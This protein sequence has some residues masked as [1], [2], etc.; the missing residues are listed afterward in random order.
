MI[1]FIEISATKLKFV[2]YPNIKLIS[3]FLC[4]VSLIL[5]LIWSLWFSSMLVFQNKILEPNVTK[6]YSFE[7]INQ[8]R[9]DENTSSKNIINGY[10]I[11]QFNPNYDYPIDEFIDF[12]Y[13]R[14]NFQIIQEFIV[15]YQ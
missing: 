7:R 10:I 1:K 6:E 4:L 3:Y 2:S 11:L 14:Q 9:L 8:I 15:R 5:W 12:E 13:G